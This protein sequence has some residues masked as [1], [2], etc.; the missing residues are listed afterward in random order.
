MSCSASGSW[1]AWE[2]S[3]LP[4]GSQ[5][6]APAWCQPAITA[7]VEAGATRAAVGAALAEAGSGTS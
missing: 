1:P 3:Y 4:L 7:R 5:L 6:R 2:W